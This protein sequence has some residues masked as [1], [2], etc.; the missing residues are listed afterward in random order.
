MQKNEKAFTYNKEEGHVEF[1]TE[2]GQ[3]KATLPL[4]ILDA[5][6]ESVPKADLMTHKAI[7]KEKIKRSLNM[8]QLMGVLEHFI[9][10]QKFFNSW[11]EFCNA[12]EPGKLGS[13]PQLQSFYSSQEA[14]A[15]LEEQEVARAEEQDENDW[16]Y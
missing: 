3:P 11:E 12:D 9:H 5:L 2:Q 8:S 6:M 1:T 14:K 16:Q 13:E 7:L 10:T 15:I 4:V